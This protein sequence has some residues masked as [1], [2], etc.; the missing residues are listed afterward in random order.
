MIISLWRYSHLVLALV[1]A[2]FLVLA[3]ITGIILAFEPIQESLKD[4]DLVP[5]EKVS[6]YT[7][8]SALQDEYDEVFSLQVTSDSY[9]VASV[10]SK[11]GATKEIYVSPVTGENLGAVEKQSQLFAWTTNL[12]R[13]LFLKG[14]GRFFVGLVS[15]LL[16]FIAITGVFLLAQRQGGFSK[17]FSKVREKEFNQRYHVILS[18]WF[19]IPILILAVSGVYLSAEKFNVVPAYESSLDWG[20]SPNAELPNLALEENPFFNS[21]TLDEVRSIQ[22]PFSE[23]ALDYYEIAL[24]S[25]EVLVHQYTGEVVSSSQY[26]FTTV[27]SR[28]SLQLHTGSGSILWAIIVLIASASILFFI[29]SGIKMYLKRKKKKNA[30]LLLSPKDESEY[31]VLYGSETQNTQAFTKDFARGLIASGKTVFMASL[32]EY[33]AFDR[34]RYLFVITATYGDGDAPTNAR[35]FEALCKEIK[36]PNRLQFSVLGFGSTEYPKFCQFAIKVDALLQQ[37]EDF[38]PLQPLVKIDNQSKEA[39]EDWVQDLE[40]ILKITIPLHDVSKANVLLEKEIFTVVERTD[41]NVD[42]TFLLCLRPTKNKTFQSGDLINIVPPNETLKRQYSIAKVHGEILLSVKKHQHGKC[43]NYLY[44]LQHGDT[45]E[46]A[47]QT[48]EKFHLPEKASTILFVGNGTGM[49]PYLGMMEEVTENTN[50]QLF[51]GGRTTASFEIYKPFV[52]KAL[53]KKQLTYYTIAHSQEATK[54]YVQDKLVEAKDIVLETLN[55]Q[56]V[57]M[58]CGSLKMQNGVLEELE[59]ITQNEWGIPLDEFENK[60]QLLMDCY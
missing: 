26:P 41:L 10:L 23:D 13:S 21:T 22:F 57:I 18:R 17:W 50:A 5:L 19:I 32:N 35:K 48:N 30:P 24:R 37:Y 33:T 44:T 43:S 39:F 4:H 2:L 14:I 38:T 54:K 46:G 40:S 49:A 34:A 6:L 59:K 20:A 27:L 12:H 47:I 25:K 31:I 51:W 1:S 3:S 45:L 36:Q 29:F 8:I 53:S 7:A 11:E 15:F 9:V 42:D 58:I 60:G 16:C 52:D 55:D 56:G 28:L